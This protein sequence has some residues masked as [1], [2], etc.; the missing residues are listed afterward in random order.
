MK[1]A[2]A[3]MDAEA[4]HPHWLAEALAA[5]SADRAVRKEFEGGGR[6]HIDRA[7]PFLCVHLSPSGDAPVAR[8]VVRANASHLLAPDATAAMPVVTAVG[9]LLERRFGAF[10]VLE[11]GELA[12][13]DLLTDKA[14][15][16]PPFK[17]DVMAGSEPSIRTAAMAFV[18]A[19][20]AIQAK[21]RTPRVELR[22]RP[23]DFGWK[24]EA[25]E[26][27]FALMRVRFAPIYRQRDSGRIFPEVRERLIAGI[28]DAA[29]HAFAAFAR[30][31][32]SL[33][34]P[35]HRALGRQAFIDAVERTDRSI[36][37]VASSFDFLLAVTPINA[38]AAWSEF[39]A[40]AFARAP[41]FLYRPLLIDIAEAKKKLFSIPFEH[42]EDPVLYQLYREKQQ[43]L[44]LQLT[45][46][47]ARETTKF[48]EFGRAL[49]GPVEP[50]LVRAAEE[51]LARSRNV[52]VAPQTPTT[53]PHADSRI[54]ESRAREMIAAYA[55]RY[56][57]FDALVEVRDDLP[58]GLLVSGRRLL[59]A[60][61]TIME[62]GRVEPILSHEI[63]VHLLTYFNGSAQGLRLF[64]SGLAGYEGMQEG[65]A[66]FA[67]YLSGGMTR[68]RL[69]LLAA[70]VLA[71]AAMIDGA[72]LP[73]VYRRLVHDHGFSGADAFNVALR[74]YRGGGLV[75]D[76]IYLRGLLQLLDHLAAGGALEPFWMGKIAASHF[77]V[78]Q[79]LHARGLLG[80][81]AV[82]PIFLGGPEAPSRLARA[83]ERLA[84]L[85]MLWQ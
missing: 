42:L 22:E 79:E 5:I 53:A 60:R 4:N 8:E 12:E 68:E 34:V 16:L 10:M 69:R 32:G 61:S 33:E 73:E 62:P 41:R 30:S 64:R 24:G 80:G 55:R 85:D 51:I 21:F 13:D 1:P 71:C 28:F 54:V 47:A 82:R 56:A 45:M 31:T 2:R 38:E 74:V 72:S 76:A 83:R 29:L 65:L 36:D 20:E 39:A 40:S 11:I 26:L 84:P 35:T 77:S 25:L 66:V 15:L 50:S 75:K 48:V 27:P 44:D 7:L 58:A 63:G 59:I 6:L 17:V 52:A 81:P 46:L 78:M 43:E 9:E 37:E 70:R 18:D 67:E 14:P 3:P 19:V 49:Y 23:Q 57:G